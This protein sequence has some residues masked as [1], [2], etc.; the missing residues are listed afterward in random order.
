MKYLQKASK[1]SNSSILIDPILN[2]DGLI[3]AEMQ[4][5]KNRKDFLY[6]V[7]CPGRLIVQ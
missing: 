2:I 7:E 1:K 4:N 5:I 6:L 3:H